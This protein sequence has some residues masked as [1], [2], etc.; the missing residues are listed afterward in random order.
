M[1]GSMTSRTRRD[2]RGS[3]IRPARPTVEGLEG[4]QLLY[5]TLGGAWTY[6]SRITYSF[7]PDGTNVGGTPSSLYSTLNA[8]ASTA[9]WQQQFQQAAALWSSYAHINL[10]QVSDNGATIGGA[11]NQQ[12][13]PNFGD[14]RISMV[15]LSAGTL[16]LTLSPPP[17]NGGSNAGDIIF[18]STTAWKVSNNY[19]IESVALHE[20]GHA[21]GLDHSSVSTAVMYAY[22]SGLNQSPASDDISGIQAVYG[23]YP[24]DTTT[25]HTIS[26]ATNVSGQIGPTGQIALNKLSLAGPNDQDFFY[27][28]VPS[29]V[30]NGQFTVVVQTANL[31]SGSP[32]L[33]AYDSSKRSFAQNT[34]P[35]VYGGWAGLTLTGVSP[36]QGYY[37]RAM[38]ASSIGS[39]GSY[40]LLFNFGTG[41]QPSIAPPNTAVAAKSDLGGGSIS[42][43]LGMSAGLAGGLWSTAFAGGTGA[44]PTAPTS[45]TEAVDQMSSADRSLLASKLPSLATIQ[46]D[47]LLLMQGLA[48]RSG[49]TGAVFNNLVKI[50][51]A[52]NSSDVEGTHLALQTFMSNVVRVGNLVSYGD[53]LSVRAMRAETAP[54]SAAR[55]HG[56]TSAADLDASPG[57]KL[58]VALHNRAVS[59]AS[60]HGP[61]QAPGA[62]VLAPWT[63][64]DTQAHDSA[65]DVLAGTSRPRGHASVSRHRHRRNA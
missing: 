34:Q 20:M 50:V 59:Y 58:T 4:R 5:A 29:T 60:P 16:A 17:M 31:S 13:D 45:M 14:I 51:T 35:N 39:Y 3:R 62:A 41:T 52:A 25:N 26:A 11:G 18:N 42:I 63:G 12:G 65:L 43:S 57:S 22:Y 37:F 9:V 33:T 23:A 44:G 53:A 46:A 48:E 21:L 49:T 38:G 28:T 61:Q 1:L 2:A 15:P 56:H 7:V 32:R 8:V 10:S 24:A 40:G 30:A 54:Y 64:T 19:D 6:G 27:V 47:A 36:G 55:R